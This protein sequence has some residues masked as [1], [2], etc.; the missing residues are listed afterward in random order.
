MEMNKE[1]TDITFEMGNLSVVGDKGGWLNL[2]QPKIDVKVKRLS[3][4]AITPTYGSEKAACMDLYS[5]IDLS[6]YQGDYAGLVIEPHQTL[7]IGTGFAFQPP[8]GYMLQILQ[9]SGLASKGIYPVGGIVDEDYRGEV[10]V[11]LHNGSDKPYIVHHGER[12]AQ[13]AVRAYT[14]ANLIK[15]DELDT[16][17]RADGGFG[18][19]GK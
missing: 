17:D 9:R 18:S 2:G 4:T 3:D 5:N 1:Q 19:T 15:V 12:I 7:K 16:T 10:I 8:S 13:M 11:A 6:F 14:Q